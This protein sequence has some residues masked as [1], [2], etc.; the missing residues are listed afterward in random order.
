M[1]FGDKVIIFNKNVSLTSRLPLGIAAMNPF[2][3]NP[4]ML[5]SMEDFYKK[6]YNDNNMRRII[7][8]INPGR[9]GAGI[10]GIPFTD[11][12]RLTTVC[13]IDWN[14]KETHEPSSAFMYEMIAKYGSVTKFFNNF[15]INSVCPLGFIRHSPKG[16]IINC[17]YYD[18]PE[19]FESV[20]P[21]IVESLKEQI[22]FGCHTDKIFILGKK[23]ARFFSKINSEELLFD[24][25]ITLYHPRYLM[26]YK[27]KDVN[28]YIVAYCE[29]LR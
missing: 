3:D 22:A 5:P 27:F 23:N 29:S 18:E 8:G 21:L 14:Q 11:S 9:F 6:Y 19:L 26:Q 12:K 25:V 24:R 20:K 1:T 17:N 4:L 16:N 7:L 10:T 13:N 2:V 28:K 15:Y